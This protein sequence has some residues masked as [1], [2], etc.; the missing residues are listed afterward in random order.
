MMMVGVKVCPCG[1]RTHRNVRMSIPQVIAR[2]QTGS[3]LSLLGQSQ[4]RVLLTVSEYSF[5]YPSS[6][7]PSL[8]KTTV[9]TVSNPHDEPKQSSFRNDQ[10]AIDCFILVH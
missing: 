1:K 9:T 5:N 3:L 10:I 8:S 7:P 6:S 2:G 4:L